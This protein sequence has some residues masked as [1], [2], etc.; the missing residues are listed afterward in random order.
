[1]NEK[2]NDDIN[3]AWIRIQEIMQIKA[4]KRNDSEKNTYLGQ[5][6]CIGVSIYDVSSKEQFHNLH[7]RWQFHI[8][9]LFILLN[10]K[11]SKKSLQ[12][13]KI[14]INFTKILSGTKMSFI[15]GPKGEM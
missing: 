12:C 8:K 5:E 15:D 4:N 6:S 14:S 10:N 1:M 3:K 13:Y 11:T 9:V 7:M 2:V